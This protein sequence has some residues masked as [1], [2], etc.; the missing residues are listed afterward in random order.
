MLPVIP[1]IMKLLRLLQFFISLVKHWAILDFGI[2]ILD[3]GYY[4]YYI[5]GKS[6]ITSPR[7]M[8]KPKGYLQFKI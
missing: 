3:L 6:L 5:K 7:R 2:R 4:D 8:Q 1:I